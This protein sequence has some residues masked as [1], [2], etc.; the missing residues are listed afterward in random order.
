MIQLF[1]RLDQLLANSVPVLALTLAIV[2]AIR[3]WELWRAGKR[4]R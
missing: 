4:P 2:Q 3:L 1:R